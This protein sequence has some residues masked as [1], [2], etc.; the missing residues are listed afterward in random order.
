[1]CNSHSSLLKKALL[2]LPLTLLTLL[3][4]KAQQITGLEGFSIFLDPGH[5]QTENMGLYNYSEAQKVLRVALNLRDMLLSQTD[6]DTVYI[7]RTNDSQQVPLTQRDDLAN[8]TAADFYQSI[9]SNAGGSSTNNTLMLHG[10]WRED[11]ETREKTPNGGKDMGDLLIEELTDAM[12]IPTIGNWADRNFYMGS[13]VNTH[14][15]ENSKGEKYECTWPYL[16]V[17]RT[18]NMASM[19]SEGGFH[20]NPTQQQRNLNAEWKRLEATAHF[21]TILRYLSVDIPE[22]GIVTGFITNADNDKPLNGITARIDELSYTTDTYQSLFNNYSNDPDE[23]SNGFY[24]FEGLPNGPNQVIFEADGFYSDTVDIDVRSDDF[25]FV[26]AEMVSDVPPFVVS[27]TL[28]NRESIDIGEDLVITFSRGMN[29]ASVDSALSISPDAEFSTSWESDRELHI[30]TNDLAFKSQYI[31]TLLD[32]ARDNSEYMHILDGD[33]NGVAGGNFT[34][35]I[36]TSPEDVIPPEVSDL[37]P[38]NTRFS[39]LRPIISATFSEPLDT[40]AMGPSDFALLNSGTELAG[41]TAYYEVGNR[42]VLNFFPE[43]RLRKSTNYVYKVA[44]SISDTLGNQVGNDIFRSFPSGDQE[45]VSETV[46][47]NFDNDLSS[48]WEPDQANQTT[49]IDPALTFK[50][51]NSQYVNFLSKSD[52]SLFLNYGWKLSDSEHLIRLY[53]GQQKFPKFTSTNSIHVYVFGDGNGNQFRFMLRDGSGEL[54]GSEW[55]TVNWLGWKLVTWNL[56]E[57]E[58]IGWVNGDGILN[59][60]LYLDSFQFTYSKGQPSKGFIVFDDLSAVEMGLATSNEDEELI[61]E[62]PNTIELKQNYPNPFNP[63]TN[64]QFGLPQR[65]EV[66]LAVYDMLGKK[67]ATVFSGTKAAG[68]HNLS[69]DASNL[70][71]GMYLYRLETD[72]EV[73]SKKMILL[74]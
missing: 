31:L 17:N 42:S 40:A 33:S 4:L 9:H 45:P 58:V 69:F 54:E 2:I 26:D 63:T 28:D 34:L 55:Y 13:N 29:Q 61:T 14:I 25:T 50:E 65:S 30:R 71:S 23:L 73:L 57:D 35:N 3:P 64:I 27:T 62:L 74:K 8:A 10:G 38:T 20:T 15:C 37:Y 1:M 52:A 6:I 21:W 43:K 70:A 32:Q 51:S 66:Q 12:R 41:T 47:D 18:T 46:I 49:G 53:R 24:Y 44:G 68:Y 72:F 11:G 59:G 60:N 19:L 39:E 16:H 5:S 48:W 22:V 67:V 7:S 36:Q 56:A